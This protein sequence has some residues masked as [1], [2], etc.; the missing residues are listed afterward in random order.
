VRCRLCDRPIFEGEDGWYHQARVTY[1]PGDGTML[2]FMDRLVICDR[3]TI[4][5][6]PHIPNGKGR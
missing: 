6:G 3:S 1:D 5:D 4:E 2:T